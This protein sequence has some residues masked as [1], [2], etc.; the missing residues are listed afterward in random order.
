MTDL[1]ARDGQATIAGAREVFLRALRIFR[2]PNATLIP[3]RE[4]QAA[5][6]IR[7]FARLDQELDA[8]RA[9]VL[10]VSRDPSRASP[11][12]TTDATSAFA[13]R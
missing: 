4:R 11:E 2:D 9:L 5:A 10:Q 13:P 1:L 8:L 6:E 7:A 3:H 12:A